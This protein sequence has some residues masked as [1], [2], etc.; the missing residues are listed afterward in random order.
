MREMGAEGVAFELIVASGPNSAL[1]HARPSQRLLQEREPIVIDIGAKVDGYCSDMTRTI[2]LGKPTA[3][4]RAVYE[5]VLRA[6]QAALTLIRAVVPQ[7]RS[8]MQ[9]HGR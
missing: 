1:P 3:K 4:F 8:V 2:C 6:Q 5:T 9:P 7:T